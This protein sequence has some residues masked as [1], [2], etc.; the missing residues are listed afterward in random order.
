M[1]EVVDGIGVC[2]GGRIGNMGDAVAPG[3]DGYCLQA[4]SL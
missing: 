1:D 4:N 2:C 3:V